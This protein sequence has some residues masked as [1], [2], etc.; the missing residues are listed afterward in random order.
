MPEA[1]ATGRDRNSNAHGMLTRPRH[2]RDMPELLSV[3]SGNF[4]VAGELAA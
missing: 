2:T 1:S 4:L 3:G